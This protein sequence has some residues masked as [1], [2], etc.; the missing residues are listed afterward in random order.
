M[1]TRLQ[2]VGLCL[3]KWTVQKTGSL[4]NL[5]MYFFFSFYINPGWSSFMLS[6]KYSEDGWAEFWI[7][8]IQ[9]FHQL[10]SSVYFGNNYNQDQ[11]PLG[12]DGTLPPIMTKLQL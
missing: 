8:I 9:I 7:R 1:I 12:P 6:W 4:Y 2:E 10:F 11:E 3:R 5:S